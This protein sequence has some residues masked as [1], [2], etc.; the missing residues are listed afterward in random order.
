MSGSIQ[1]RLADLEQ[2]AGVDVC[3]ACGLG[4]DGLPPKPWTFAPIEL[5]APP[6]PKPEPQ[7]CPACGVTPKKFGAINFDGGKE[8]NP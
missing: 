3:P 8:I 2:R 6:A 5:D 1:S 7:P 4:P